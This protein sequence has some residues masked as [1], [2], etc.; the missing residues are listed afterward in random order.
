[1]IAYVIYQ[2]GWP[3]VE[4]IR[5]GFAKPLMRVFTN[6]MPKP[7]TVQKAHQPSKAV[8]KISRK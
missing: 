1:M 2:S 7:P 3:A 8:T 6:R 5:C 4:M